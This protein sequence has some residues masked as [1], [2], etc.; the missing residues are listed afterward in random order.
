VSGTTNV[1]LIRAGI[2]AYNAGDIDAFIE[3]HAPDVEVVSDPMEDFPEAGVMHGRE[4][5]RRWIEETRSAWR[6]PRA[7][8][9]EGFDVGTDRA[10]L[11][12]DS[13]GEGAVSGIKIAATY[14]VV[15]TFRDGLIARAEY[16]SDHAEAL[17]AVGLE[18]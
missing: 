18:E 6:V 11:R 14:T 13:G 7:E 4:E 15:A 12:Y 1:D 16:H 10:V 17:K 9:I 8:F 3:L 2:D 5:F